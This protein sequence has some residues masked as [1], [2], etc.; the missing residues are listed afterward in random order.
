LWETG[1]FNFL[2][3]FF[4]VFRNSMN[5]IAN[6]KKF[7]RFF[8]IDGKKKGRGGGCIRAILENVGGG[9]VLTSARLTDT[10]WGGVGLGTRPRKRVNACRRSPC[11][12]R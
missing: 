12:D 9:G 1:G 10:R 8:V 6:V 4:A 7:F 2:L 5:V 11:Y 3:N